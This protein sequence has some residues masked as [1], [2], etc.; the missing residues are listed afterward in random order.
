MKVKSRAVSFVATVIA[1]VMSI[2]LIMQIPMLGNDV[3]ALGEMQNVKIS[4]DGILSWD[5]YPGALVY[6]FTVANGGG[7]CEETSIDLNAC[8][9]RYGR[10]SG[11]YDVAVY[12]LSDRRDNDGYQLTTTWKGKYTY[13]ATDPQ[14]DKATNLTWNGTVASWDPVPNAETYTVI[15]GRRYGNDRYFTDITET[16]IDFDNYLSDGTHDYWFKVK[17]IGTDYLDGD[18]VISPTTTLSKTLES[19][20]NIQLSSDGILSWD[21]FPGATV[22][23]FSVGSGGGYCEG[24]SIDLGKSLRSYGKPSGTY[25]VSIFAMSART[26]DGGYQIS[27]KWTGQYTYDATI[28]QLDK[29]T[30]LAWDGTAATWDAVPNA[31][32]YNVVVNGGSGFK[33]YENVT[34]TS[35]DIKNWIAEGEHKYYFTVTAYASGYLASNEA[36]SS[37]ETFKNVL[38]YTVTFNVNGHGTAPE[39]QIVDVGDTCYKPDKPTEPGYSFGGWYED[40]ACT[41]KYDFDT[42]VTANKTLYGKWTAVEMENVQ[43]SSDGILSWDKFPGATQYI[44]NLDDNEIVCLK[45]KTSLDLKEILENVHKDA[46]TYDVSIYAAEYT[47][48]LTVKWTGKYTY[49]TKTAKKELSFEDFVERLYVV[50]LGRASEPEGKAFWSEHVGNGDLT[51][52]QCANEFLLSQEFKGR[53]LTDEQFLTVLYS[54][55]FDRP[56]ADDP[57]GFNFWMNSLKTQGRDTVVDGF[58][59][60]AEWCNVC[61]TYGVRSGATRAKATI[62]SENATKFA[63]RLYT[64]CL[65]RDAE[66]EGLKFWSLGLTNQELSGTQAAKE[67]FYCAEFVNANYNDEEYITRMYKTFMGRE[68]DAEGKAYWLN[69]MKNG[70]TRDEV[71]NFFSTCPEFTEICKTYAIQR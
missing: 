46:G 29:A 33:V 61:A 50:A 24:T 59:N 7:Y 56:A 2:V 37:Y 67:F 32:Y 3:L 19:M 68:P 15:F 34:S 11:T 16:S 54:V 43:I 13:T 21:A 55:F 25:D 69:N 40:S 47:D 63:T 41:K 9:K 17:A 51:G 28:P 30:N 52:A 64:E 39:S 38:T 48:Q 6:D 66:E 5:A 58:I 65:G 14:L 23:D 60:S 18:Y 1:A 22:Y 53:G 4:E 44:V 8:L 49:N 26:N 35:V 36:R 71:F 31:E 12:A 20:K 10:G 45:T 62:A 27:T 70:T 42:P 57:D